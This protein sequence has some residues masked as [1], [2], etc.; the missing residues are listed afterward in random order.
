MIHTFETSSVPLPLYPRTTYYGIRNFIRPVSVPVSPSDHFVVRLVPQ[1]L[2]LR[3]PLVSTVSTRDDTLPLAQ[4]TPRHWGRVMSSIHAHDKAVK[5][6][7]S[8]NH[9][10]ICKSDGTGSR[11]SGDVRAARSGI[12]HTSN[13]S[14]CQRKAALTKLD[15]P[16]AL[17][18]THNAHDPHDLQVCS[19]Q[20]FP[21]GVASQKSSGTHGGR[22]GRQVDWLGLKTHLV[23]VGI[24]FNPGHSSVLFDN[25]LYDGHHFQLHHAGDAQAGT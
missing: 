7:P 9:T 25:N 20:G 12:T 8:P 11:T 15:V 14:G 13:K 1:V 4:L 22:L 3:H 23:S 17:H 19:R 16:V 5:A 21:R 6:R 10:D 2:C 18:G 24:Y